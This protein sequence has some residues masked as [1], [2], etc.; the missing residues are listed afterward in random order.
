MKKLFVLSLS[1]WGIF[2]ALSASAQILKP[3]T[4][5]LDR[6]Q[7]EVQVGQEL[8]LIFKATIDKDWYLYSTDFDPELGPMVTEFNFVT[9]DSYELVGGIQPI[10]PKKKYD[11]IWEGEY[12]YFSGKGEFRQKIKVKSEK[13]KIEGSY[14]YQVCSDIDGKCIP[15]EDDFVFDGFVV[16]PAAA[17]SAT[18]ISETPKAETENKALASTSEDS[19]KASVVAKVDSATNSAKP[20]AS[21]ETKVAIDLSQKSSDDP[22]SLLG[23]MFFAFLGGL[24]ALLTPCV[25][26]MIP[27]TVT[28]FTG[29][30]K[31]RS[32]AILKALVYGFSIIFIYTVFGTLVA[33]INGPEFANWLSTHWLPN[34][35]FFLIFFVFA[36]AFLGMFELTLPSS[37]VNKMDQ[38]ADRGGWAGVFFMAF[39]LVLVSF[40]CTG[41]IVGSLLVESAGGQII[42]PVLGMFAFSLA[43]ALPFTLFAIFPEWLKS[44]PKSGGWLNSVKVVLGFL[45]LA[46]ALKFLSVADQV[47]HW[48]ILDREIYLAFWIVIFSLL[49]LY[50]LG[51]IRLPHDSAIEKISVPRV[52]MAVVTFTFVVYLIP[53]MFGAPLKGLAGYLP[54]QA[55][56]DFN[57]TEI[58]RQNAGNGTAKAEVSSLC[59]TPK[60]S[61]MLHL[62]HGLEGYFDYE[63]ALACARE[64]K[65]P[66]FIDFT[67]HGCVNC[68]EMEARVWSN[69]E[70]LK[71]LKNDFVV[72]AL[73]VDEKT[74][75]PESEWYTSTYDN[76]VK[77]SIGK[78]NADLQ[79]TR[80]NN[81]AQPFYVILD[82]E[83][84]VLIQPLAY[85][86]DVSHFI[87]FLDT[88][89][90]NYASNSQ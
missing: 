20:E 88:A 62:P 7:N 8:E 22:Y 9:N 85:D 65:K 44:L 30:S 29:K 57:L 59:D 35:L 45:E 16:K 10:N 19:T 32:D 63:Q 14:S 82:G 18:A 39:T 24:A 5:R 4:W 84:N 13:L 31:S 86:L 40:S 64:Q 71:R 77:K 69:P 34:V 26:P 72:V 33:A 3:I 21:S 37:W 51:K 61:D 87:E 70:V 28:F 54:P 79:I 50:F 68:R 2:L 49:G 25:F 36:L 67:G 80:Y 83:E 47:Y 55:T 75:L 53:G 90:K 56:H 17:K 27:M 58:I 73:Y 60:Y 89:K 41:P 11:D 48:G 23:F 12:T 15:F 78:Q 43:F 66:L 42:K 38:K 52:L 76:K 81:N 6:S 74:E 46:L 1:V